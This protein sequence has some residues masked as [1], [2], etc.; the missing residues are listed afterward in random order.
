MAARRDAAGKAGV[1]IE[2]FGKKGKYMTLKT[3]ITDNIVVFILGS[4]LMWFTWSEKAEV[5]KIGLKQDNA[6]LTAQATANATYVTKSWF[7]NADAA[8][9]QSI[10]ILTASITEI[11]TSF[12]DVKTSVAVIQDEIHNI[13]IQQIKN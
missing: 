5:E 3:W 8:N 10:A 7:E 12:S 1:E 11:K 13:N 9:K 6:I 4:I 2:N